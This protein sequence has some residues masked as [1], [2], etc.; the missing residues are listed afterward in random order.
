MAGQVQHSHHVAT[1]GIN[2]L[3]APQAGQADDVKSISFEK[4]FPMLCRH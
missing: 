1:S 2:P 3:A 4:I